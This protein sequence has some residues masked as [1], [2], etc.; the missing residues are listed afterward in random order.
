MSVLTQG[1]C[2]QPDFPRSDLTQ[3]NAD[4]LELLLQN[5]DMRNLAHMQAELHAPHY[6]LAHQALISLGG[7]LDQQRSIKGIDAGAAIYEA[8][9]ALVRPAIPEV[10]ELKVYH[11]LRGIY[12][13]KDQDEAMN[14]I[15]EARSKFDGEQV[16][17]RNLVLEVVSRSPFPIGDAA[18]MGAALSRELDLNIMD[19]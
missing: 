4:M 19:I 6:K 14:R 15:L 1:L 12:A 18:L 7:R 3:D 8:V 5:K 10:S 11:Q 13:I 9:T 16:R 2:P 17:T